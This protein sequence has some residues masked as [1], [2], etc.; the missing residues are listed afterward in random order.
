MEIVTKSNEPMIE[1]ILRGPDGKIK[2]R[3]ILNPETGE[4]THGNSN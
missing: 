1:L 2:R 3:D 4:V